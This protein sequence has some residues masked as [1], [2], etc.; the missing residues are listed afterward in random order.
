MEIKKDNHIDN[1]ELITPGEN[2]A[3]AF[4]TGLQCNKGEKH[5]RSKLKES[6]VIKIRKMRDSGLSHSK[7][8]KEFNVTQVAIS[9]LLAGKTWSHI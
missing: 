6:D 4:R 2:H 5:P 8:A 7:I 9:L 1:L 3:H